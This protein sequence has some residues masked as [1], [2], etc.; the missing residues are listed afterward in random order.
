MGER[1]AGKR[2]EERERRGQVK[3]DGS[4]WK[5]GRGESRR[6]L[7]TKRGGRERQGVTAGTAEKHR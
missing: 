1:L 4:S 7:G 3:R 5:T 2:K 6:W